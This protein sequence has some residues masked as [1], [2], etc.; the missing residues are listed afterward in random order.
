MSFFSGSVPEL[1]KTIGC[2]YP[3]V[4]GAL[5]RLGR[6]ITQRSDRSVALNRFPEK[7]W[8]EIV[9]ASERSRHTLRFADR[10]GQAR[11]PT[12]LLRRLNDLDA[13]PLGLAG[14]LGARHWYPDLDLHG[15][16]RL[17]ISMHCPGDR[18]DL[19]FVEK[20]DPALKREE[21]PTAPA[22]LVIH[23]IRRKEAYF[24]RCDEGL[25]IADPVECMLDLHELRLEPQADSL[26][27]FLER[28]SEE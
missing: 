6:S 23:A 15:D 22:S 18:M 11:S 17:D 26:H 19:N 7:T 28:G 12:S 3:T 20:L 2:S 1:P 8:A 10:S 25:S 16:P 4:A 5:K 24:T 27:R 21:D 13:P 14:T 9:L